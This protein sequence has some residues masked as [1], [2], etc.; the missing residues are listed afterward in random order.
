M[1]VFFALYTS[2]REIQSRIAKDFSLF[3]NSVDKKIEK[4]TKNQRSF[5]KE[6]KK[7][8][9]SS[10]TGCL[11]RYRDTQAAYLVQELYP[12]IFRPVNEDNPLINCQ[13]IISQ[14]RPRPNLEKQQILEY[15]NSYL[16]KGV[17]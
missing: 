16:Y 2:G 9:P 1:A 12:L 14:S 17:H 11:Y 7:V 8:L 15:K 6:V 10:S 5:A 13:Y 3:F 4:E